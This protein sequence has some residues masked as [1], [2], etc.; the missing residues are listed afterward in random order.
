MMTMPTDQQLITITS[1][2]FNRR[3]AE[4]GERQFTVIFIGGTRKLKGE[5]VTF[6]VGSKSEARSLAREYGMR[7][8]NGARV[9]SVL[10]FE[11]EG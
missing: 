10:D 7:F 9:L 11:S 4:L 6:G 5:P 8:M 3:R 1:G 2:D